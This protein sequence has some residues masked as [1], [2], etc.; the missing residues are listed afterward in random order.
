MKL[1]RIVELSTLSLLWFMGGSWAA[2][3]GTIEM[4]GAESDVFSKYIISVWAQDSVGKITQCKDIKPS[5][6]SFNLATAIS[7]DPSCKDLEV[8][9]MWFHVDS[10]RKYPNF[11]ILAKPGVRPV[12]NVKILLKKSG[13]VY[14][15]SDKEYTGQCPCE[16][17]NIVDP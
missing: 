8:T 7:T 13:D 11:D 16:F 2:T 17:R 5:G 14:L 1:K 9:K 12:Y 3:P 15:F 4:G 10:P 6:T